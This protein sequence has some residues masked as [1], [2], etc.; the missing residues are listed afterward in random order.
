M[1]IRPKKRET[2]DVK[3]LRKFLTPV[4]NVESEIENPPVP[5][6]QSIITKSVTAVN[7]RLYTYE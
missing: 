5:Q 1:S 2:D 4:V 7:A 3:E 6:M